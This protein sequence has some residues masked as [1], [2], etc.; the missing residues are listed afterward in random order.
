M[1]RDGSARKNIIV[2]SIILCDD[3]DLQMAK[4]IID[5][6]RQAVCLR[7]IKWDQTCSMSCVLISV[8]K[9]DPE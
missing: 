4:Q 5:D 9:L 1:C 6:Q 7:T 2:F 8:D 3:Y